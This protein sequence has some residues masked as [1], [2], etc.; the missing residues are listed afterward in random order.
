MSLHT[1]FSPK[2]TGYF[3]WKDAELGAVW[4]PLSA[5]H[6]GCARLGGQEMGPDRDHPSNL[7]QP[8]QTLKEC[9]PTAQQSQGK[10]Q[11]RD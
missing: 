6:G 3:V 9:K 2:P 1:R 10:E 11:R 5:P 4:E 8:L 7:H